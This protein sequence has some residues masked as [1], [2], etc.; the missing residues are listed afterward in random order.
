M[1]SASGPIRFYYVV[2]KKKK[3]K[4]K[5]VMAAESYFTVEGNE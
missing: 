5:Y 4:K 2:K 1:A 3:K